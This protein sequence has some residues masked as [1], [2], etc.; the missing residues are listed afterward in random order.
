MPKFSQRSRER[1]D[2]CHP[3]LIKLMDAV[4]EHI[5]ITILCGH[6]SAK[7]QAELHSKGMTK[8]DGSARGGILV[9]IAAKHKL[10][11][12]FI[13]VGEGI[14]DLEPFEAREFAAAIAGTP[15]K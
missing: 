8:L 5:D 15:L 14:D 3:D 12:Y 6:R 13:G 11:V 2:T 7:E 10:P 1:L 9:A 4:I